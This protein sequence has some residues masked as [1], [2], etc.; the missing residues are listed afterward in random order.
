[1]LLIDDRFGSKDMLIPLQTAGVPCELARLEFGDFAFIGRG[2]AGEDA[3]IGVELKR[4]GTDEGRSDLLR[5]MASGRFS[6]HQL[7]GLRQTYN[8]SWLLTEGIHRA[9]DA[10]V[11]EVLVGGQWKAASVNGRYVMS[12]TLESWL[13]TQIIRGGVQHW[14]TSTRRDT[15]RFLSVLYQWW[16]T[17]N[18]DDHRSHQTIYT[19]P[20]ARAMLVAPST[21]VKMVASIPG[22]GW[23]KAF[24]LD[25]SCKGSVTT[26]LGMTATNLQEVPG[27][28]AVLAARIIAALA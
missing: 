17:K 28:G 27:V 9:S 12:A 26:L 19:P 5:S 1:M 11:L 4:Y 13:L 6:G 10:G 21:F 18:L 15:V 22:V 25:D 24:A 3:F 14:H 2:I 16:C 8:E 7:I 23:E 20:P